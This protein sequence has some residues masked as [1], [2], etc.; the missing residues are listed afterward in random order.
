V[1]GLKRMLH[2]IE[3]ELKKELRVDYP[4]K[5]HLPMKKYK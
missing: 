1:L 3:K 2:Q 4:S 5:I